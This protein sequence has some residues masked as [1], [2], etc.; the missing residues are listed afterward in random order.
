MK[1]NLILAMV[2]MLLI[3]C[4]QSTS[5]QNESSSDNPSNTLSDVSSNVSEIETL[6]NITELSNY[7]EKAMD[8]EANNTN[9]AT[10][11]SISKVQ[12][13]YAIETTTITEELNSYVGNYAV[14]KGNKDVKYKS[15]DDILTD[16]YFT[17]YNAS[18]YTF[19]GVYEDMYYE[20]TDYDDGKENDS[21]EKYNIGNGVDEISEDLTKKL[22]IMNAS[23]NASYYV[24]TVLMSYLGEN[25]LIE[26]KKDKE[27]YKVELSFKGDFQTS[28]GFL[29]YAEISLS[30]TL[31]SLGFVSGYEYK[32]NEDQYYEDENG[33]TKKAFY[34]QMD[35][36]VKINVGKRKEQETLPITPTDYWMQSYD[37]QIVATLIDDVRPCDNDK[38]PCGFYISAKAINVYPEK[39]LDTE[40]TITSSSNQ[41]AISVSEYGVIKSNKGGKTL[42]NVTSESG[43]QKS[44]EVTVVEEAIQSIRVELYSQTIFAGETYG[45]YAYLTPENAVDKVIWSVDNE[46]LAEIKIDSQGYA[47]L[48]CKK[49]GV[50]NVIAKSE[51]NPN[52]MTVYP[53]TIREKKPIEE[54]KQILVSNTWVNEE[55]NAKIVFN[56]DNTCTFN[57]SPTEQIKLEWAYGESDNQYLTIL[58]SPFTVD[59]VNLDTNR[60]LLSLD[61][62]TLK[63]EF[64]SSEL[65]MFNYH[66]D[67]VKEVK[68]EA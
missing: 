42:L 66:F 27:D 13:L 17:P 50:V 18:Y 64:D 35:D 49:P 14:I 62:E 48:V 11:T 4:N 5:S 7:L 20:I 21:A 38:I 58:V 25:A 56:S 16:D 45:L 31:S 24:N 60:C 39:A 19:R 10:R 44:I 41:E 55:Q 28:T 12:Q 3:S 51:K 36:V 59:G 54:V 47:D 63:V 53:V 32:Y 30:L 2:G 37:V 46:E 65:W 67:F 29:S 61:G 43:I 6:K 68:N 23:Y 34:R 52:I 40:L 8:I 33:L 57:Y 22:S 15:T 26:V 9:S 1:K